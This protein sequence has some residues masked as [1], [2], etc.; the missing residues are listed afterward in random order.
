MEMR[1]ELVTFS[2]FIVYA[3][4]DFQ[5]KTRHRI[6]QVDF[7]VV[8][9]RFSIVIRLFNPSN[10]FKRIRSDIEAYKISQPSTNMNLA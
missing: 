2:L 8:G 10:I 3:I 5:W 4:N 1:R 9:V 7:R 6:A